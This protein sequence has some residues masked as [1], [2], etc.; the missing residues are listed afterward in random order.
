MIVYVILFA[1]SIL[2]AV[3]LVMKKPTKA[4]KAVYIAVMF[5]LMYAVSVLRYGIGNDYFSYINIFRQIEAA[6]FSE[7][8]FL[9]FE[10][11]FAL[12]T[13]L[14]TFVTTD[15]EVLY[16]IFAAL[17]LAPVGWAI[18]RHSENAWISVAVYLCFT[19]FY[20]SLNFIRQSIAVSVIILAYGF[21]KQKKVVP[22]LIFGIAAALLHY[23]A[24]V[25]IPFYL[26]SLI[27][28]TKKYLI[29]YSSV[30]VGALVTCLIMKSAGA[31][32]LNL[33]ADLVTSL[34]GKDY[35]GYINSTWFETGFGFDYLIMPLGLLAVVLI[36]YF[37]GWKEKPEA[38]MLLQLTLM[39]ATVWSFITF[40]F[41]VE[42]FSMFIFIFS[43]FTVPSVT[44]YFAKKAEN[45]EKAAQPDKKIPGYSKKKSEDSRDNSFLITV[46]LT[47]GMFVYNCFG[48]ARNFHGVFPYRCNIPAIEDALDGFDG[49][50]ENRE[51]LNMN[52]DFYTFLIQLRNA[53]CGYLAVSTCTRF[54]GITPGIE[55]AAD[56][57]GFDLLEFTYKPDL[58]PDGS[59]GIAFFKFSDGP[60]TTFFYGDGSTENGLSVEYTDSGA[61][62]TY[63]DGSTA[64]VKNDH[65][66]FIM[67]D[68]NGV[69]DA[70]E[71]DL[72][73][74]MRDAS[75]IYTDEQLANRA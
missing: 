53:D 68:E 32:P 16:A 51:A 47:A 27:R 26:L 38:D 63:P 64:R 45:A 73:D 40:A 12:I 13:K 9:G 48:M 4:K 14:L 5:A 55:R 11:L 24:A 33:L 7:L 10:P 20:T 18:Y 54:G 69:F 75:K 74:L 59:R 66:A 67:F 25:F 62:V 22:V 49:A 30:S 60:K 28:P 6:D 57:T 36:S 43:L 52:P 2:L 31:N 61:V 15:P 35:T 58:K 34:T 44:S 19:F 39:N 56:Y 70:T 65:L 17:I 71:Y 23:T 21:M 37:C 50:Q 29:I 1:L 46:G 42:R 41:I 8:F 3:P 72:S